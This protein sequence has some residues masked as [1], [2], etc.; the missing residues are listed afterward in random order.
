[1]DGEISLVFAG[2]TGEDEA[3]E[4]LTDAGEVVVILHA[5]GRQG[6]GVD[7]DSEVVLY[8]EGVHA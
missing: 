7:G 8:I 3:E 2:G 4:T 1:M 5:V 6:G